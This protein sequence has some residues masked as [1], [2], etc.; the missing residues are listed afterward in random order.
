MGR[1]ADA[2]AAIAAASR[3]FPDRADEFRRFLVDIERDPG[4][5]AAASADANPH[6]G[7]AAA[8]GEARPAARSAAEVQ[9]PSAKSSRRHVAGTIDL[10]PALA[11]KVPPRAVLFVFVR[12]A[13]VAAGP[14]SAAKRLAPVFPLSFDLSED[15]AMMGQPFPDPLLVEARL[16][17]DGDPTTRPP[18][19]PK[20]RVDGVKA[21]R[22][23]VRLVLKRQ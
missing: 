17:E 7:T 14:P 19:D 20:A 4:G 18:T 12:P 22:T 1:R 11:G 3:R 5:D 16:D 8:A 6:A 9:P 15:D 23:D 2:D 10:D 13:G 21:G